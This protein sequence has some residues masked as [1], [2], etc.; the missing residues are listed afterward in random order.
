MST[1]KITRTAMFLALALVFQALR[2][3]PAVAAWNQSVF[4]I[5]TL[6]NMTL[7]MATMTTGLWAGIIIGLVTP[8]V[9]LI[10]GHIAVPI[11]L[12]VTILGNLSIVALF[13]YFSKVNKYLAAAIASIAKW[14][15]M[16]YGSKLFISIFVADLAPKTVNK[17]SAAANVPQIVTAL[18]GSLLA[19]LVLMKLPKNIIDT[20][21]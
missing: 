7:I 14:V 13:Y 6:V 4:L 1:K 2:F 15:V 19:I 9:A 12:P 17:I 3:I 8:V 18:L 16:F 5:G 11:M 10:Q 21:K 20:N